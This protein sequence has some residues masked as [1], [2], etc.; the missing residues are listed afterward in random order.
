MCL[1]QG[2]NRVARK[3]RLRIQADWRIIG[4][5]SFVSAPFHNFEEEQILEA[6]GVELEVL[7]AIIPIIQNIVLLQQFPRAPRDRR[8]NFP[9]FAGPRRRLP[10][11]GRQY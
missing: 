3:P 10:S 8:N 2:G 7:A 9:G 1:S 6:P 4:A 11:S 5:E